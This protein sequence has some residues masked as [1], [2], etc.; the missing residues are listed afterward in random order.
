MKSDIVSFW[1]CCEGRANGFAGILDVWC[2][3]KDEIKDHAKNYDLV[4]CKYGIAFS[5]KRKNWG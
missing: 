2:K 3:G 1:L 5:R 4:N